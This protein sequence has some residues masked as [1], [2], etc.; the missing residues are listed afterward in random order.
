[1]GKDSHP[2]WEDPM[3]PKHRRPYQFPSSGWSLW[4]CPKKY[5]RMCTFF[6]WRLGRKPWF[7]EICGLWF[8]NTATVILGKVENFTICYRKETSHLYAS[9]W[10]PD[11]VSFNFFWGDFSPQRE[12]LHTGLG[13]NDL[14]GSMISKRLGESPIFWKTHKKRAFSYD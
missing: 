4:N 14:L 12:V 3:V 2:L 6:S 9:N 8:G 10:L 7:V 1:M 5:C 13:E 11:F